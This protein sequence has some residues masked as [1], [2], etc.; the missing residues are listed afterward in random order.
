M[1]NNLTLICDA[2]GCDGY[3]HANIKINDSIVYSGVIDD[4]KNKFDIP[5]PSGAGKHTLSIQR[6]GKTEKNIT[7]HGEQI[8]KVNSILIDGIVVPKYIIVDNSKFEFNHIV[9]HGCLDFYPNGNW[10]FGFQTPFITWCMDQK[11]ANDAK[12]SNNYLLP[13]S[14]QLGPNQADQLIDDIDQLFEKLEVIHD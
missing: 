11:I 12:F 13:W 2:V 5:I 4:C 8:L 6:Y 14:Y 10:T 3:P 9:N 1:T 7:S